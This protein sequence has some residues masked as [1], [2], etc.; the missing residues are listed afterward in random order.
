MS[1]GTTR[2]DSAG[3][4]AGGVSPAGAPSLDRA[5]GLLQATA[6]NIISMVGVGPFL[7]IPFMV[8]AMNGPH[9]MYAWIAGAVLAVADGLVYAQLGAALPGSG[10]GYL[11]LREAFQPFGLGRLMAFLFIFQTV[12]I[13]PLS[14]AG[15][16]VGFADYLQFVWT[17]MPPLTHH[18]LAAAVCIGATALLW[19]RIEDIGRLSVVMLVVVLVTV[20]WVIV[21]GLFNFSLAQAFD[22]PPDAFR[23]DG[24][25]VSSLGAASVLAM[26]SYGGY[27]QVCNIGDEIRDPARTV[28]RS[29]F[30]SIAV[31]AVLYMLMTIVILGMIPWEQ[32]RDSRTVASVFIERTFA[33]PSTG[34]IAGVMM[35]GLILFVA[36]AS[37]Y[38]TILGYSRVPYAAA[39]DGDFFRI[40]ARVHQTKHFP[41]VSLVTIALVSIPFCFFTLGQ[42]VSWLIQVQVLLRFIWQCAAVVLLRKYRPDIPQPFTMVLYPWPAVL[43]GALWLFIF[44]TG[45]WEGIVFSFAFLL[46]G[47]GAYAVFARRRV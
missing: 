28:P 40:F 24:A 14:V 9:V 34:R 19:R 30:L 33:D 5:I 25:L 43:S 1:A 21:A 13:A 3:H 44:V 23:F 7:T 41:D 18:L 26:Y 10:G 15:G 8:A 2:G 35:T 47:L 20:G 36:A 31:V 42:L 12:L 4:A 39:R 16:A 6:T 45:P 29:I 37:L 46:A 38:A 11:Y 17:D 27:N 32:V 22:Y